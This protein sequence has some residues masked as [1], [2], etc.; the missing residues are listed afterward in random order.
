MRQEFPIKLI[1]QE[2]K[3][4]SKPLIGHTVYPCDE[5]IGMDENERVLY[6]LKGLV[7]NGMKN[8]VGRR[9]NDKIEN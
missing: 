2:I 9:E 7:E 4:P 8:Y 1:K 5:Y 6:S 3:E